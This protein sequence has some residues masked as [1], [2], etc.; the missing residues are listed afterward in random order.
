MEIWC[1]KCQGNINRYKV[2]N[3]S[4]WT[5]YI[6]PCKAPLR[7]TRRAISAAAQ[8]SLHIKH[9]GTPE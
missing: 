1:I 7:T 8:Y 9:Q 4:S 5:A 2:M 3:Y 6:Q